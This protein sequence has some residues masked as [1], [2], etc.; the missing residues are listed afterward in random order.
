MIRSVWNPLK[1]RTFAAAKPALA[2]RWEEDPRWD[3]LH[4]VRAMEEC[5]P[6]LVAEQARATPEA[7]AII[8]GRNILS[9]RQLNVRADHLTQHL[10]S[11]GVGTEILVGLCLER[12]VAMIVGALGILKAGGAFLPLDPACPKHRLAWMLKD[13]KP[14]VLVTQS[15][16]S[17][18]LPEGNWKLLN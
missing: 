17:H 13:A 4:E 10:R 8:D 3:A 14:E 1:L 11:L 16:I 18:G 6:L 15:K 2:D 7:P 5:V 9:Y 12:S